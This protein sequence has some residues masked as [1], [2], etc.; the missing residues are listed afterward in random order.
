[1]IFLNLDVIKEILKPF[2]DDNDL[3]FISSELVKEDG[4]L[5]LRVIIDN[6]KNQ[7]DQHRVIGESI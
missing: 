7:I 2:L 6:S 1:M 5:I 4:N 3:K